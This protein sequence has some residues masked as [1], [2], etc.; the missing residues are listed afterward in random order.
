M[1]SALIFLLLLF[2]CLPSLAEQ[3]SNKAHVHGEGTFTLAIEGHTLEIE[4]DIPADDIVG[5]EHTATTN[6]QRQQVRRAE[7]KLRQAGKM[8][9]SPENARCTATGVDVRSSLSKRQGSTITMRPKKRLMRSFMS[10]IHFGAKFPSF[11]VG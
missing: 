6:E 11:S 9:V 10:P 1:K 4:M 7:G 3:R 5:F 2:L 8:V